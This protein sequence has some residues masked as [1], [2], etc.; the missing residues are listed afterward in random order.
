MQ[1]CDD[2][3]IGQH[4]RSVHETIPA[5]LW[6]KAIPTNGDRRPHRQTGQLNR[7][8]REFGAPHCRAGHV[9]RANTKR[10]GHESL[11]V[12]KFDMRNAARSDQERISFS[13]CT[14]NKW[15]STDCSG[16]PD[17]QNSSTVCLSRIRTYFLECLKSL[18]LQRIYERAN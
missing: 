10:S 3:M 13:N 6:G 5:Y 18:L 9:N 7:A 17:E 16:L 2:V 14:D 8:R 12:A 1:A 4:G 15:G 11:I